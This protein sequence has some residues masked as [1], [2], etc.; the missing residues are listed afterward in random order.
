MP[1]RRGLGTAAVL[2]TLG[3]LAAACSDDS[4]PKTQSSGSSGSSSATAP[5]S[6]SDAEP[7]PGGTLRV[8]IQR[9]RSLD[10]AAASPGS[11][12]ELLVADLLFDGLSAPASDKRFMAT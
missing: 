11:Q 10:P 2:C 4:K 3:L 7:Q 5:G 12:S 9:P 1:R 6:G 8:G